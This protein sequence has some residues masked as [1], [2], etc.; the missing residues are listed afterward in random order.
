MTANL[1][2]LPTRADNGSF[3]VVVESPRGSR[4]KIKFDPKLCAFKFSRPLPAGLRYPYD[5]GFIPSTVGPDGDPL[6]AMVLSDLPTFPGVIIECR[7]LGVIRFKQNRKKGAGRERNDRLIAIPLK[8][9]RFD[10]FH[11]PTDLPVRWRQE[12]EEFFLAAVRFQQKEA[13][14]LGWGSATEGE[15][16]VDRCVEGSRYCMGRTAKGSKARSAS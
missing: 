7:A 2:A 8:M 11:K 15:R 16:M 3:H 1:I 6:D 5:W 12:L 4:V 14:I 10:L 13:E 9:P